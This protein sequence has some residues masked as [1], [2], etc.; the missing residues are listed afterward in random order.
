[1]LRVAT[2]SSPASRSGRTSHAHRM[3]HGCDA[4]RNHGTSVTKPAIKIRNHRRAA[5][6]HTVKRL[7]QHPGLGLAPAQ[8]R[9]QASH[10]HH[11][12]ATPPCPAGR[13]EHPRCSPFRARAGA[14]CPGR[15][16]Q[17]PQQPQ[18]AGKPDLPR[19]PARTPAWTGHH[20]QPACR[21]IH[22]VHLDPDLHQPHL[23]TGRRRHRP[24]GG[25]LHPRSV[26]MLA[27]ASPPSRQ[28]TG[29]I[30]KMRHRTGDRDERP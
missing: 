28:G 25:C 26:Q 8:P 19:R 30:M 14:R 23:R 2:T 4:A 11:L 22:P 24:A 16:R 13:R 1:M 3:V 20:R 17:R 27:P 12:D 21:R 6:G 18:P 15:L 29:P 5:A 7:A 9:S 10:A